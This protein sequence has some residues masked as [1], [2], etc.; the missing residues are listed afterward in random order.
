[1]DNLNNRM[2]EL[3]DEIDRIDREINLLLLTYRQD[4]TIRERL[5]AFNEF[6]DNEF[7]R[8]FRLSKNTINEL[9]SLIGAQLEPQTIRENFNLSAMDKILITLR[10]Y[11]TA[12]FQLVCADFYGVSESSVCKIIPVV[13]EKIAALREIFIRMPH[14]DDEIEEK[15]REFFR[16][17]AMPNII[18]ALDGTLIKIQEVGGAQN[19]TDF[20]CRKQYYAINTQI[21]CDANAYVLDIVARWPGSVH[22]ET[23]F[24]NSSLFNRFLIGE[25]KRNGINSLILADGGYRSEDF[26]IVPLRQ[27]NRETTQAD[28]LY[29]KSHIS[30]R[31]VVERFMGQWKKRF[32]CLWIG[33]RFRKLETTLNVI[34]ATAVLHNI[35][36]ICYDEPPPLTPEDEILYNF[37]M[38]DDRINEQVQPPQPS[39]IVN[40]ALRNYFENL[41]AQR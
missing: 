27:T 40:V 16:V 30:T 12:S 10:Y 17:A 14:T 11:A 29:Q 32:P 1:M 5:S 7:Q 33:M 20:F 13:S 6:S 21:A 19:K 28:S 31:N 15:K 36:K 25:F 35:C 18:C 26:L 37:A 41:A 3:Q 8:R 23:V 38:A 4:Y 22:D 2:N 34:V 9:H 39:R 24:L